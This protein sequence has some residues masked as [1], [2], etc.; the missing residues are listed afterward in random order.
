MIAGTPD[1][2]PGD[3]ANRAIAQLLKCLVI[4]RQKRLLKPM[5]VRRTIGAVTSLKPAR[6]L[7]NRGSVYGQKATSRVIPMVALRSVADYL[8][9]CLFPDGVEQH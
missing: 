3:P 8:R 4:A 9:F 1:D 6:R 5:R 7:G 2:C